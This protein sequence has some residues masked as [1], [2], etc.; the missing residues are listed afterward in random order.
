MGEKWQHPVVTLFEEKLHAGYTYVAQGEADI[1][2]G[3]QDHRH[4]LCFYGG[5]KG[6][7]LARK[8]VQNSSNGMMLAG[9]HITW[10]RFRNRRAL[11]CWTYR[12]QVAIRKKVDLQ[13]AIARLRGEIAD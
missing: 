7:I 11:Q 8:R 5:P 2:S 13:T 9:S 3:Y 12:L 10:H 1:G 6:S 4:V